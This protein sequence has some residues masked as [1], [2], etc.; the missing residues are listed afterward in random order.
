VI[1]MVLAKEKVPRLGS[2]LFAVRTFVACL[3]FLDGSFF[4][5]TVLYEL[6]GSILYFEFPTHFLNIFY[7]F[8]MSLIFLFLYQPVFLWICLCL[9]VQ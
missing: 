1:I 6:P 3:D 8:F 4:I 2:L 7:Y 9:Y 5:F